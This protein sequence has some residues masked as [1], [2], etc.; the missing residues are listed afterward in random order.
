MDAT[1]SQRVR[2]VLSA[3]DSHAIWRMN[4]N[5]VAKCF[6]HLIGT[7]RFR[8]LNDVEVAIKFLSLEGRAYAREFA[9]LFENGVDLLSFRTA[10]DTGI[11]YSGQYSSF[12]E[13]NMRGGTSSGDRRIGQLIGHAADYTVKMQA[14]ALSRAASSNKCVIDKT[15]GGRWLLKFNLKFF[16][17]SQ[18]ERAVWSKA[19]AKFVRGLEGEVEVFLSFPEFERVFRSVEGHALFE[20]QKITRIV[21][22]LEHGKN[23]MANMPQELFGDGVV[24]HAKGKELVFRVA[25]TN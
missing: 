15:E 13:H 6:H 12:G 23:R 24:R 25:P 17:D 9:L 2:A 7:T 18:S 10:K 3:N 21:Y 16:M 4:D 22:F 8:N 19:S 1:W 14:V 5:D 20:N 11:L